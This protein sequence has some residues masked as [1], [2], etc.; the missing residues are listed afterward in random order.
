[1]VRDDT[2]RWGRR[3][4]AARK[5]KRKRKKKK[6]KTKKKQTKGPVVNCPLWRNGPAAGRSPRTPHRQRESRT[7]TIVQQQQPAAGAASTLSTNKRS[8][9]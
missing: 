9:N 1:M 3:G 6:K 8:S 5:K 7:G 4:G 2:G